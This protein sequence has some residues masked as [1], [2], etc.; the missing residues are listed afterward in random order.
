[1]SKTFFV[2]LAT[3]MAF[4]VS[5]QTTSVS[6]TRDPASS[7]GAQIEEDDSASALSDIV[8]EHNQRRLQQLFLAT[9]IA[10]TLV[11]SFDSRVAQ[12]KTETD[13]D[14]LLQSQLYCKLQRTRSLYES[15]EEKLIEVVKSAVLQGE[16][17]WF[18]S[19]M[20]K[21][22][23]QDVA[24]EA[25]TANLMRQFTIVE[26]EICGAKKCVQEQLAGM[27]KLSFPYFDDQKTKDFI[28][29]NRDQIAQYSDVIATDLDR[30]D[31]FQR[32]GREP[33]QVSAYD[34]GERNHIRAG[35][36]PG[37]F[38]ITYDDGPHSQ[39]TEQLMNQW[40]RTAF[41][42]PAF[43]WL[44]KNAVQMP[45]IVNEAQKNGFPV[46]LHSERHADLG[47]LAKANS[48]A[49]FN[50]V[51]RKIFGAEVAALPPGG[52]DAWKQKTLDREIIGAARS[53]SNIA[54]KADPNYRLEHFRLPFGSG[55]KN[56]LI[57]ARLAELNVE[58]FFWAVDSLDWQ[59]KNPAS[60]LARVKSQMQASQRGIILFHD[61]QGPTVTTTQMLLN[62]FQSDS[63]W[64]PV[65]ISKTMPK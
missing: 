36:N 16:K 47:V 22:A 61:I 9:R 54:K 5:C 12:L 58:H 53:L 55:V 11:S 38:V 8:K 44:S 43:F 26:K 64:K 62:L 10:Q 59:D 31:C 29:S 7:L 28:G 13:S 23:G 2:L 40:S 21:F 14:S 52:F 49:D 25:A 45:A 4:L 18:F 6:P 39:Y 46:A 34:W 1:M 50:D 57:G 3:S 33:N 27:I 37:E 20:Q 17:T 41:A 19:E 15:V 60:V 63:G 30:G 48:P 56:D 35:L 65:S 24:N 51:D 32:V 42:K